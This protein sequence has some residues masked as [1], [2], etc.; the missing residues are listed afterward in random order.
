MS[1]INN[2]NPQILKGFLRLVQELSPENLTCDGE[3][4]Q[5]EILNKKRLIQNEWTKLEN[6]CGF[7]VSQ[8]EIEDLS[9]NLP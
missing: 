4:S 7:K 8:D 1:T 6:L 2:M 5:K 3:L 9:Y